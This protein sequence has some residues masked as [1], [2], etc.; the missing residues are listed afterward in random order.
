[1]YN[2][3]CM[4]LVGGFNLHSE[5]YG[6]VNRDED[7]PNIWQNSIHVSNHQPGWFT[8]RIHEPVGN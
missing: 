2:V 4:M 5:K 1:M 3:I 6:F 8:P 7:I